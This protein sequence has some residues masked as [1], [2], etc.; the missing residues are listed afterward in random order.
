MPVHNWNRVPAGIF[1][2]FHHAWIE[3]IK[4]SLNAG[5]LP[6][7]Y[8]A[9][10]EQFAAGLGP[11]VLTLQAV[12]REGQTPVLSSNGGGSLL[13]APPQVQLTAETEME[14]YRRKQRS[15]LVRHISGDQVVA[16]VEV[17]SPGNKAS[18]HALRSSVGKA[19]E[20]LDRSI[21]LLVLDVHPP[22]PRD[23]SGMHGAIWQEITGRDAAASNESLLTLAAYEC[24]PTVRAYVQRL[25]L[26]Q[27]LPDMPL[28][29]EPG[30]H[31]PVPLEATYQAA[32]MALPRRW[33]GVLEPPG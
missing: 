21:H 24:G 16:V 15:V 10:A 31:V 14:F 26:G 8:Y 22:G 1:H 13:T 18:R 29:L 19:T 12:E 5:I 7:E 20:L 9:L 27:P 4:R 3:E 32:W 33:R 30:G 25:S 2:D 17:V 11:D 6:G 23:P 28:F